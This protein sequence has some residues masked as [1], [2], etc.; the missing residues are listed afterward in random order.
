V[1]EEPDRSSDTSTST[2]PDP[3]GPALGI[4]LHHTTRT[5]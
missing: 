2:R 1:T 5:G 4:G 3:R